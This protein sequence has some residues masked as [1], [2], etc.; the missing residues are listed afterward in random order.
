MSEAEYDAWWQLHLRV[1]RG[2][3]LGEWEREQYFATLHQL[4]HS[5]VLQDNAANIQRLQNQLTQAQ[6]E[7]ELLRAY[8]QQLEAKLAKLERRANKRKVAAVS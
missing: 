4:E 3:E 1:A 7:G 5:E 8:R 2:E 6:A